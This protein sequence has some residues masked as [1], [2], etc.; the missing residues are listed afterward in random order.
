MKAN[1]K[2]QKFLQ[3]MK[4][5]NLHV[6]NSTIEQRTTT[7]TKKVY[8]NIIQDSLSQSPLVLYF[9]ICIGIYCTYLM[10]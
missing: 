4:K 7:L 5:K 2:T 3:K 6:L 8:F 1:S 9:T 10:V